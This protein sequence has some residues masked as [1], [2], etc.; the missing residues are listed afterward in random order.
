MNTEH[1]KPL[2][3]VLA[4]D[5]NYAFALGVTL[6]SLKENS[7]KLF[8]QAEFIV[9]TN[10]LDEAN[11]AALSKI[12]PNIAIKDFKLPFDASKIPTHNRY[13]E[14][15]LSRYECFN[16]LGDYAQVLW[17]DIDLFIQQ[18]AVDILKFGSTGLALAPDFNWISANFCKAPPKGFDFRRQNYNAG[19]M[20][21]GDAL[22]KPRLIAEWCYKQTKKY[23]DCLR[24]PDQGILNIAA[25]HFKLQIK[26][27]P[28]TFN[29][30][31]FNFPVKIK[32][33]IILHAMGENKFWNNYPM[34]KWF[35]LH[36]RWTNLGGQPMPP[37]KTNLFARTTFK[38][39]LFLEKNPILWAIFKYFNKTRFKEANKKHLRALEK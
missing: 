26:E 13:T 25:Q 22:P 3:I 12:A 6:L 29:A 5:N 16:M 4:A 17:L 31:P 24:W 1:K 19:V 18:E 2:A 27:L 10:G 34:P 36:R 21:L 11:R 30:Q 9:Y 20:L 28:Q 23:A 32:D 33:A 7:P 15:T 39:K 38:M 37:Q 14:L 35:A 8:E